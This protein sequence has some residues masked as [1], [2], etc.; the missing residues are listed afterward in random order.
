MTNNKID[1][2]LMKSSDQVFWDEFEQV[3]R[4]GDRYIVIDSKNRE[5]IAENIKLIKDKKKI[6]V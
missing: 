6:R 2:G 3:E 4:S 5:V 1:P